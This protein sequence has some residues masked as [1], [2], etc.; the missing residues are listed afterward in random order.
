MPKL[1][2]HDGSG[3][4]IDEVDLNSAIFGVRI[5]QSLVHQ[6][7]R[8]QMAGVRSGSASTKTRAEAR[9][10]GAKPWRQK[11][12]GRARAGSIR[13]PVWRGGGVVFGPKPKSYSFSLPKKVKRKA[14]KSILSEKVQSNNLLVVD[15]PKLKEPQTKRAV[16]MLR[17][18]KAEE[19]SSV[20]VTPEQENLEKS[21]RNLANVRVLYLSE[22]NPYDLLDNEKLIFTKAAFEGL[23]EVLSK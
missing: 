5:D 12:T 13:S 17:N 23:L 4:K 10:G 11:G 15:V 22:V 1:A 20:V 14:L 8:A 3:K 18:L 16:Q 6:V 21:L 19:K 9:G 2:V 7:I